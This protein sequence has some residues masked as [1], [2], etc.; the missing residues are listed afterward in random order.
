MADKI[1]IT[2]NIIT[3][4][5]EKNIARCLQ[6]LKRVSDEIVVVDS[7]STDATK[8]ICSGFGV[9]FIQNK[10]KNY[11][12]QKNYA[13]SCSKYDIILS[14]DADEALSQELENRILSIKEK[15]DADAYSMNR[16]TNYC[17]KWINYCG[18]Y[19]DTK[20]RLFHKQKARW[21]GSS[22]HEKVVTNPNTSV[23]HLK[24]DLL[25]YSYHT[26]GGHIEKINYLSDLMAKSAYNSYTG[27][28]KKKRYWGVFYIYIYPFLVFLK[29]YFLKLGILDGYR[30][31]LISINASF[32]RY[33]K[34]TKLREKL[35]KDKFKNQLKR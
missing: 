6:S 19:P 10:F 32:Y 22:P 8:K 24:Y 20:I 28:G 23:K 25:H 1:K 27:M 16:R 4:N 31:F 9:K 17:G 26:L 3:Y 15:W 34:Y 29:T 13:I 12:Q 14:L 35:H 11:I 7:F 5:E 33:L 21:D 30:G 18:W 2:A